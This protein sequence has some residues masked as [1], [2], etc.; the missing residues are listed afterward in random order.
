MTD[1][2][3]VSY[4]FEPTE[5][6]GYEWVSVNHN[7]DTHNVFVSA[8]DEDMNELFISVEFTDRNNVRIFP[9]GISIADLENPGVFYFSKK[10]TVVVRA[11]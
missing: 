1:A 4:T 10:F 11:L 5:N 2:R 6:G 9:G 8:Y 7:F 3:T